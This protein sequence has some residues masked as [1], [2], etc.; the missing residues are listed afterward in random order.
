MIAAHNEARIYSHEEVERDRYKRGHV[1]KK[2]ID[3]DTFEGQVLRAVWVHRWLP[4]PLAGVERALRGEVT[5]WPELIDEWGKF[6]DPDSKNEF[7]PGRPSIKPRDI[8]LHDRVFGLKDNPSL[9]AGMEPRSF[10]YIWKR[11]AL[12]WSFQK[13]GDRIGR[14][15]H[16]TRRQYNEAMKHVIANAWKGT[17]EI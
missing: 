11:G 9:F 4:E 6:I 12:L 8:S 13:M 5:G 3:Q 16:F 1:A 17:Y 15:K 7:R 14:D 2:I 10:G